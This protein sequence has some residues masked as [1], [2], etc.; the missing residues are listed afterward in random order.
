MFKSLPKQGKAYSLSITLRSTLITESYF[1]KAY[2]FLKLCRYKHAKTDLMNH[3]KMR[4]MEN[5]CPQLVIW[6]LI[7]VRGKIPS[8]YIDKVR[9]CAIA[10]VAAIA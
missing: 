10:A 4:L 3:Q 2:Q 6:I 8:W 9:K 5:N 1:K 7:E